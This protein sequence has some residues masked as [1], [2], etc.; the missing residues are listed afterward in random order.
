MLLGFND[1]FYEMQPS[2]VIK[3]IGYRMI[4]PGSESW[5]PLLLLYDPSMHLHST[6]RIFF[7]GG[8]FDLGIS[9][10]ITYQRLLIATD[11]HSLV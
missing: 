8:K 1:H 3:N 2:A 7:V 9:I 11:P 5:G 4:L 10:F 6:E